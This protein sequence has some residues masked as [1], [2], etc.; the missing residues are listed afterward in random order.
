[1]RKD[2]LKFNQVPLYLWEDGAWDWV[3]LVLSR[4]CKVVENGRK[5]LR[6]DGIGFLP[7]K[8]PLLP[9]VWWSQVFRLQFRQAFDKS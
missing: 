9:L 7:L 1:M 3:E 6:N 2:R 4:V 5:L 8:Q